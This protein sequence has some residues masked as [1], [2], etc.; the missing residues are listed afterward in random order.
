[1]A[2]SVGGNSLPGS[3]PSPSTFSLGPLF[4]GQTTLTLRRVRQPASVPT[5]Y[6]HV[7]QRRCSLRPMV[8]DFNCRLVAWSNIEQMLCNRTGWGLTRVRPCM[9]QLGGSSQ[10]DGRGSVDGGSVRQGSAVLP[11]SAQ[12]QQLPFIPENSALPNAQAQTFGGPGG[13]L[14]AALPQSVIYKMSCEYFS[15][16]LLEPQVRCCQPPRA[17]LPDSH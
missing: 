1:V 9:R 7:T 11:G 3:P 16:P 8:A 6:V 4:P 5:L 10:Q 2:R 17:H 15:W 14:R 13:R 12:Q